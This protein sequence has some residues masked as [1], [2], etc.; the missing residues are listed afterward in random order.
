VGY[1]RRDGPLTPS[2]RDLA[3]P[4]TGETRP[5]GAAP[6][7]PEG[8]DGALVLLRHGQTQFIVEKRFQGAMEA[9]LT[10]LGEQQARLA[11]RR[12]AAPL[13]EPALPIPD[14][15]PFAIV[16]SP[17][18]RARRS[19][20]LA[21]EEMNSAGRATPPLRAD[22]GYGEIGQ[23][24][25]EGLTD[26]EITARFGDSLA[27]WR[28]WPT[29]YQAPGGE[30]LAEVGV[31]VEK[32]LTSLLAEMADGSPAGTHDR[33]Q[34]LGYSDVGS[35]ARRWSLIVGHGGVFRAITCALLDLPL[36]HFW[37]FDFGLGAITIVEIRAGRAVLRTLNFESHLGAQPERRT[38]EEAERNASG[39]L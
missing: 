33:P 13:A 22:A 17:L 35:D 20:E 15:S 25:W 10:A 26:T 1:P 36:D 16:H 24:S 6:L 14:T 21:V 3:R 23:G 31:R 29:R 19:A 28:R 4:R 34:V 8:L 27:G 12:L 7:I 11:G 30:S 18:G 39:A 32:A 38:A 2:D 9:P 5:S 37:N